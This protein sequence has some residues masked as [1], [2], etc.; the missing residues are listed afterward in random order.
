MQMLKNYTCKNATCKKKI[1][2]TEQQE[3]GGNRKQAI[4]LRFA[5]RSSLAQ[6]LLYTRCKR[7]GAA[8]KMNSDNKKTI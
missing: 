8:R 6:E 2:A 1:L 5:L 7:K 3:A 4:S